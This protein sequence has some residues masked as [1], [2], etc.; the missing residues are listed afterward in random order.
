MDWSN[1]NNPQLNFPAE[2]WKYIES[3]Y[4]QFQQGEH[5]VT[6]AYEDYIGFTDDYDF[7]L[8]PINEGDTL[9]ASQY[10]YNQRLWGVYTKT[11]GEI[12]LLK[13]NEDL[14]AWEREEQLTFSPSGSKNAHICFN[15]EGRYEIAVEILPAGGQDEVWLFSY[16]Y[17]GDNIR[18]I[19][20]GSNPVL[21][22]DYGHS[23]EIFLFYQIYQTNDTY[24][25]CYR[26][27]ADDYNTEH[28][29]SDTL[30]ETEL[31]P[32]KAFH[33]SNQYGLSSTVLFYTR[34]EDYRPNKYIAFN[35]MI[36]DECPTPQMAV[37]DI[38]WVP[39]NKLSIE[40]DND[41]ATAG[42]LSI[43]DILWQKVSVNYI[44]EDIGDD[45]ATAG[46]LSLHDITW[47]Q[48]NKLSQS[49]NEDVDVGMALQEILWIKP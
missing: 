36:I 32:Q 25:I 37:E 13:S 16:P 10:E 19:C 7:C 43:Q 42:E 40:M 35:N 4:E 3:T 14:S 1:D 49:F 44:S 45:T 38:L 39:I 22:L 31:I 41:T 26:T 20:N 34:D 17:T 47:H 23:D 9:Q 11:E 30:S 28:I 12:Y 2:F 8:G 46:E 21:I 6:K 33:Y 48:I 29:V 5:S 15:R 27:S 24:V 18:K